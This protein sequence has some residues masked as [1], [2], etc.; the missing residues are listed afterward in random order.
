MQRQRALPLGCLLALLCVGRGLLGQ[1]TPVE[2]PAPAKVTAPVVDVS[3]PLAEARRMLGAADY[4]GAD[5]ALRTILLT[6][7][8]S[9]DAHFMLGFALLHEAQP[10][11]SLAE[12]TQGAKFRDPAAEELIGVASDYI[13]LKDYA[14]AEKWLVVAAKRSPE[15][16]ITW[17]LLGRTQYNLNHWADA[18]H[19]FTTCL[20]L[21]PHHLRAEYNLGLVY[22]AQQKPELALAAYKA[23]IAW[24]ETAPVK[25]LQP[26]L[27]EGILL[28]QQGKLAEALPVLLIAAG[29]GSHNPLAHQ[30]LGLAY[31]QLGK[32][33]EAV[34]ELKAAI[35]LAPK[36]EALHFFLGRMYRKAG[37][38]DEA[39]QEFAEAAR[40]SG[41]KSDAAVP[42]LDVTE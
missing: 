13:L 21:D 38:K 5:R 10:T 40:L 12:Y 14:D 3:A 25:D 17:Y 16:P 11:E 27:D 30:E 23:A 19:S 1:Q 6:A 32:Y 35:A 42:N 29:G 39:A 9:P 33:D 20:R 15:R 2:T 37:K 18:E 22:E 34:G 24:Q 4:A 28:R 36:V 41:T 7:P 26:Y 31:E 8:D